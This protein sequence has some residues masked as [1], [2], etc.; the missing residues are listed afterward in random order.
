MTS[1]QQWA[2]D[3][4]IL[5]VEQCWARLSG[6]VVG[7]I[8]ISIAQ[9]PDI[10]PIN[11]VVDSGGIVFR[12]AAGTKLAGA[13]LGVAVA[14]EV[15]HYDPESSETWSVVIK[16]RARQIERLDDLMDAEALPLFPWHVSPKPEF[17]R[18]EPDEVTGRL[19]YA[20]P[21]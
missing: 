10:F 13:V 11:Y 3:V 6:E 19:F 2:A 20:R 1:V 21:S 14:F 7:R 8:A 15:D 16:G 17:V 4:Q 5:D 18:I 12:T 9:H